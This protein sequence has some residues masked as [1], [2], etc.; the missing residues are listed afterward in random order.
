M[1]AITQPFRIKETGR[2]KEVRKFIVKIEGLPSCMSGERV[3][4]PDGTSGLVMGFNEKEA[5]VISL[6]Y[7]ANIRIGAEVLAENAEFRIP[8]G[9]A[10]IGRIVNALG[11]P[12]DGRGTILADSGQRSADSGQNKLNAERY[13]LNADYYPVFREAP[14]TMERG[15]VDEDFRTGIKIIDTLIPLGKGQRVL[16]FGDRM[17]GKTSVATDAII[18]QRGKDMICIYCSIGKS[19]SSLLKVV[20]LLK[21]FDCFEYTALVSAGAS[22]PCAQQY[23]APYTA[24]AIGE[25]F[26]NKGKDV[27]LVFDDLTKHAWAY[28]QISLL[29]ERSP[30]REAYPGDIYYIHSQ[31]LE[32]SGKLSEEKGAGSMTLFCIADTLQGDVS[33]YIPSNL[34]SMLDGQIY[35]STTLFAEGFK[36]AIDFSSSVSIIGARTQHPAIKDAA[37]RVK[38]EYA[39]YRELLKLTR[40]KS[41]LSP[42]AEAKIR[43]GEI[44]SE[45]LKQNRNSPVSLEEQV[46]LLY[47]FDR[48]I[49]DKM[50]DDEI[51]RFKK[52]F[53]EFVKKTKP[54]IPEALEEKK[55]LSKAVTQEIDE[56]LRKFFSRA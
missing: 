45:L 6:G 50:P 37:G 55:P 8:V 31:L 49:L 48:G 1:Q 30:G 11:E 19:Y 20:Q 39:Q 3:K 42:E 10:L 9:E 17:S 23:L 26:M 7:E 54:E 13:T 2:V 41:A 14:P 32:R 35:L 24:S 4:F 36:P 52:D 21:K 44:V 43:R 25:Y 15:E 38:I 22:S 29:L 51:K 5:L 53:F 16:V 33:G 28:R 34:I 18:N 27:L 40:L 56:C 47:A 12:C 46:I